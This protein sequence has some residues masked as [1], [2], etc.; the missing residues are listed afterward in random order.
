MHFWVWEA[1]EIGKVR[2]VVLY[3]LES[4]KKHGDVYKIPT[5]DLVNIVFSSFRNEIFIERKSLECA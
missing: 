4:L 1:V 2:N 3:F 5:N